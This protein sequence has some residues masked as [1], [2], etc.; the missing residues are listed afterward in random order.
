M[1]RAWSMPAA[2]RRRTW[3]CRRASSTCS[4]CS[5]RGTAIEEVAAQLY[6]ST[7]TV[8]NYQTLIR[9]KMGLAN[10]VEMHRYAVEHGFG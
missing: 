9:K 2:G 3:P 1:S 8:A 7:K 6:L 5:A 10:R 4:A